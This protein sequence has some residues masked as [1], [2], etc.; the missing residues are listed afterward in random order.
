M[1]TW[2]LKT[3]GT[4]ERILDLESKDVVSNSPSSY[5]QVEK[6]LFCTLY[7]LVFHINFSLWEKSVNLFVCLLSPTVLS[8][9]K[10]CSNICYIE[11][12]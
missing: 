7:R 10:V 6:F 8:T 11:L 12:N 1:D 9:V 4:V 2:N 5:V 3:P